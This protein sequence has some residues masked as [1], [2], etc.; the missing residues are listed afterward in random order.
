MKFRCVVRMIAGEVVINHEIFR[1]HA[2]YFQALEPSEY[3]AQSHI[4][5][6]VCKSISI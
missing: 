1:L 3:G 6:T 2:M 5:F 4:K